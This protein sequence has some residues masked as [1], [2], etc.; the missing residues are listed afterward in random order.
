MALNAVIPLDNIADDAIDFG[1]DVSAPE[2]RN[3]KIIQ[4]TLVALFQTFLALVHVDVG[5][6]RLTMEDQKLFDDFV[7]FVLR[8]RKLK[9]TRWLRGVLDDRS[10]EVRSKL[11]QRFADPLVLFLSRCQ[12][13]C[14]R[15]Q[16][17]CMHS[18]THSTEIEH[19]C[20]TDHKCRGSCEY[21][22]CQRDSKP[23]EVRP[24]SRS[25]GHEGKC[26]CEKGEHTCGHPCVLAR[27]SNCDKTCSKVAE[28]CGDH[29]CSVQV[30]VCG[31]TCSAETCTAA[32]VLDTQREHSVHK[33]VEVQCLHQCFMKGCK[34]TC[35]E[36]DHF[37][38]QL[39]TSRV[40]ADENGV[41]F[42]PDLSEDDSVALTHMC[43]GS[44][45]CSD[46]CAVDGICEQKV[47][48]KKSSRTYAGARGSFEYIYQEMNA[49]KKP[50]TRVL[51]S[52]ARHHDGLVHSCIAQTSTTSNGQSSREKE[53][54]HQ[55]IHYCDV[56]CPCC[57]NY[58]NKHFGHMGLHATSHGNMR[59]TYFLAKGNDIDIEDRKY[60]VG[61]RG[62]AEMCNLFCAKMGRGHVHYLSC[63]GN[64]RENC[65]YTADASKDHRRH[66]DEELYPPPDKAMDELL[67]S[68]FWTTIGWED[69]CSDD[70]RALFAKCPFQCDAPEHEEADKLPSYCVLDA[71]HLPAMKPEV[72][73]GFAY[74]DDHKFECKHAVDS[75]TFHNIFVLDSS[76][77]MSGQ[78]WQNLLF[79]C[80]EFVINRLQDG[81]EDDLVSLVTFDNH[82]VIH[83]EAMPLGEALPEQ[84]PYSGGGT[85]FEQGLRTAS[86][87][88]SRNDYEKYK[89][90]LIFFSDG[91]PRD[92]ELGLTL[93]RHIRSAYAKYDLT[94]FAVGFGHVNLP[95]LERVATEMG[96]DYR[97]VLDTNELQKEFQRIAAVLRKSEASLALMDT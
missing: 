54:E 70:E 35:G 42:S 64:G 56:R 5:S 59:Q 87:V 11:E 39:N 55:V 14:A 75:G 1:F 61:E 26:E 67:H 89:A 18:V 34:H 66:C 15:C 23:A 41:T 91:H 36:K 92:I 95:V 6:S 79:A 21:A 84:L 29:R 30:H 94:A 96:G 46:L 32:C 49:C 48:L 33:C 50:C 58:C 12:H 57:N 77:S 38:G 60:Q 65:V 13:R 86:E 72:D 37:H 45:A 28:H 9:V 7:A 82:S 62:I 40:F 90:V 51:P 78:P 2:A 8:R 44:H 16:L 81:G 73:D 43:L 93:A 83:G 68:Q 19:N 31:A 17:G 24:C 74:I 25:A 10:S 69:P 3:T 4:K 85:S 22:E 76:G 20:S 80:K 63:E 71:W 27:A 52:G 88:L 47:H 53:D 97:H